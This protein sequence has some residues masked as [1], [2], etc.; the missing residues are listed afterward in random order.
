MILWR[1]FVG[2]FC[3]LYIYGGE[4]GKECLQLRQVSFSYSSLEFFF[5]N[6]PLE[7]EI[8]KNVTFILGQHE[9]I[10]NT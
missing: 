8:T 4:G 6:S 1:H 10:N 9:V 3:L 5:F 2:S 7:T